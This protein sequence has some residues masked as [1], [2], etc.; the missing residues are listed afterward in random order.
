MFPHEFL[1]SIS[2]FQSSSK[3]HYLYLVNYGPVNSKTDNKAECG[4][5][6]IAIVLEFTVRSNQ[7]CGIA[8]PSSPARPS[9]P[10]MVIFVLQK[11]D[12][13]RHNAKFEASKT[14]G[15]KPPLS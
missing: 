9:H 13:D 3:Q 12:G 6:V 7:G 15:R 11:Q 8:S 5:F 2:C 10:N 4:Y 1:V 14:G